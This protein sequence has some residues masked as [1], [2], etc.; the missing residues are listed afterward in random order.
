MA[1]I[2]ISRQVYDK[3]NYQGKLK[4]SCSYLQEIFENHGYP[5]HEGVVQIVKGKTDVGTLNGFDFCYRLRIT[6]GI[7]MYN[8]IVSTKCEAKVEKYTNFLVEGAI[9]AISDLELMNGENK[10]TLVIHDFDLL[11]CY[12]KLLLNPDG[13]KPKTHNGKPEEHMGYRSSAI[14]ADDWAEAEEFAHEQ[15]NRGVPPPAKIQKTENGA[16]SVNK[17]RAPPPQMNRKGAS[18]T[19]G[20]VMPIAAVTPYASNF[21]IHG[22]VSRKE[23]MRTLPAKNMKIFNFELTDVHGDCIRVTAFNEVAESMASLI[24]ENMSYYVSGGSVRVANKR[25]NSTG[26]DYEITLRSDSKVEPGGEIFSTPKLNVK[27]VELNKIPSQIG[28]MIDVLVVVERMDEEPTHFTSRQGKELI[29]RELDVVDESGVQIRV[30]MWG[31]E[32]TNVN[33]D[34][35]GKVVLF[36]GLIP[37]EFNG[38]YSLNTTSSTRIHSVPDI[39]GVA[40]LFEW[41]EN[42]RPKVDIQTISQMAPS[43]SEAPR[44]IAGIIEMRFGNESEKGDYASLK[45]MITRVNP[46]NAIYKGCSNEGCQK[47]VVESDGEYRCEKC[48]SSSTTFKWLYMIQFEIA[49]ATGQI[50]VTAFGDTAAK[51]VG[52]SAAEVGAIREV[53]ENEYNAVFEKIQFQPK[54]WRVRCKMESYNEEVRQRVTV[55]S[56]EDVNKDKYIAHLTDLVEQLEAL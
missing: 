4:L 19:E 35:V 29:K 17:A 11:S 12:H 18:K 47:K 45:A 20:G 22:M 54:M 56:V 5:G 9:I 37:K 46:S 26:H 21:K 8:S 49:D 28:N 32:A 31:E 13:T 10:P 51:I 42:E 50:Y 34:L 36:K 44:T 16:A 39:P 41:Y 2:Q 7:F 1:D 27:R 33:K 24:V 30:T 14:I 23:E 40:E 43:N 3:F 52:K 38:A 55:F 15:E 6:D 25:F 53:D 48:N